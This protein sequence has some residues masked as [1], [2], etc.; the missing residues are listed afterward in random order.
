MPMDQDTMASR[1]AAT[2]ARYPRL[3][4]A[5]LLVLTLNP[6]SSGLVWAQEETRLVILHTNDIYGQILPRDG[7]GGMVELATLVRRADADLILDGGDMFTGTMLADE[8]QGR[9]VIEIMNAI[10]YDAAA[11]GNHEFDYGLE[12]LEARVREADFP[13]LSANVHGVGG[14]SAPTR[15]STSKICGLA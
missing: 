8:F 11:L 5:I 15:S 2:L 9:L 13:I 1:P 7:I 14:G 3:G 12:A 4:F 6:A 10:G